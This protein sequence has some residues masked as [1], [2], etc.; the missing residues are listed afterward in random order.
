MKASDVAPLRSIEFGWA[1]TPLAEQLAG[2]G[3]NADDIAHWQL[4]A[5]AVSRIKVRGLLPDREGR[6]AYDR[7]AKKIGRALAKAAPR[8]A[9][10]AEQ[11]E[12]RNDGAALP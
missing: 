12:E 4:D 6:K 9:G 5:D 10:A 3:L 8:V 1:A 2:R 7:L 11:P